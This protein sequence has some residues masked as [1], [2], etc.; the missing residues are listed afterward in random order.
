MVWCFLLRTRAW[1]N[2]IEPKWM[3]G[4]R[5]ILEPSR[6]LMTNEIAARVCA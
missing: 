3:H 2:L 4:K 6:G 1:L 5:W